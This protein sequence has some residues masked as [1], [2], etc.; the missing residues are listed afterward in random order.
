M[1]LLSLFLVCFLHTHIIYIS[2]YAFSI[3]HRSL[4]EAPK[5]RSWHD[6][7]SES[8]SHGWPSFR[9]PEVI[10]DDARCM[11][12]GEAVSLAGT[13][14]G[15]NLRDK[16]GNRTYFVVMSP[17]HCY[18]TFLQT[19]S[20]LGFHALTSLRSLCPPPHLFKTGYCINLVSIAGRPS[21]G[22]QSDEQ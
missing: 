3:L 12:N 13:H 5:G 14:L 8:K 4:Y 20:C 22:R 19:Y 18:D 16:K 1:C 21:N 6:F 15:H 9:D 11:K 17:S 2:F 7:L 10:W